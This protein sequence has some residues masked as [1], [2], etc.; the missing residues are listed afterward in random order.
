MPH[1]IE[2]KANEEGWCEACEG[3]IT[4]GSMI[5]IDKDVW[6][7]K[8]CEPHGPNG[9]FTAGDL[10]YLAGRSQANVY[11]A[12]KRIY[13]SE[14]ADQWELEREMKEGDC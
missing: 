12:E 13:G 11:L 1:F 8:G 6:Y 10:E 5:S 9:E 3:E 7:H 4:E 2:L 14:L